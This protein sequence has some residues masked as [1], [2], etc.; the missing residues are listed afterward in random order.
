MI[1]TTIK[2]YATR[3][4]GSLALAAGL[5]VGLLLFGG[6]QAR[7]AGARETASP[8]SGS[9]SGGPTP[10]SIPGS[11]PG[12]IHGKAHVVDGDTIVVA[13]VRI[14]LE[15]IDAPEQSQTCTTGGGPDVGKAGGTAG[16]TVGGPVG[17][18][19]WAC[20]LAATAELVRMIA[21]HP[22]TC[23]DRGLDK[24]GRVLATCRVGRLDINAEMVRRGY[25]W[26]FV[27]YSHTYVALEAEARTAKI[28][29]WSGEATPAW[30][31]RA[32]RWQAAQETAP[33]GCAIKGNVTAKGRIYHLPWSPWY[34]KVRMDGGRNKRWFCSEAE[35]VNAGWR[36]A[37]IY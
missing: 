6:S 10:G 17:G 4:A 15:G 35:A 29:I 20:G 24:Y 13:G 31:Y 25:A 36:P 11:I 3:Q 27:R 9:A 33:A 12:P 8:R 34:E 23:D 21:D 37:Q 7:T 2:V 32:G 19:V 22:V 26:A 1:D 30:D 14:R 28:G 5:A 18:T 16:R